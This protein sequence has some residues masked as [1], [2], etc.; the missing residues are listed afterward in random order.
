MIMNLLKNK[1][2]LFMFNILLIGVLF[3]LFTTTYDLANYINIVFYVCFFY[4]LSVLLV[5]TI[6]GGFYD[7]I[8]FGF[9]RFRGMMSKRDYMDE[10]KSKPLPSKNVNTGIYAILKFQ[11][12]CL[13]LFLVLLLLIY[14]TI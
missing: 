2:F 6:K 12:I 13:I 9:R 10:W 1:W 7:G 4:V 14:Y 5:Y 8:T 11:S 3:F